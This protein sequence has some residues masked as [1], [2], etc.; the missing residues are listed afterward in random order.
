MKTS[1][2][3]DKFIREAVSKGIRS[4]KEKVRRSMLPE[5]DKGY[6]PLG[7][8][9]RNE[10]AKVKIM[11]KKTWYFENENEKQPTNRKKEIAGEKRGLQK[12]GRVATTAVILEAGGRPL[13][14]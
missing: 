7:H 13:Q 9:K 5:T 11:K 14:H 1:G 6:L 10:R 4:F 2:H 8:W 3:A 12:A